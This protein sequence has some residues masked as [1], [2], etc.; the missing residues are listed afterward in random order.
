LTRKD[1]EK[2]HTIIPPAT[3]FSK[4]NQFLGDFAMTKCTAERKHSEEILCE[5]QNDLE[6]QVMDRTAELVRANA[7]LKREIEEHKNF[8]VALKK[9]EEQYRNLYESLPVAYLSINAA[10]GSILKCN[11][12]TL[13]MLGYSME[14]IQEME[15]IDLYADTPCGKAKAQEVFKRFQIGESI[16]DAVLEMKHKDGHPIWISLTVE[17]VKDDERNVIE[18]RSMAIDITQRYNVEEKLRLQNKILKNIVEGILL[19]RFSDGIIVYTSPALERIFGYESEELIGK[20]VSV[21]NAPT[22]KSPDETAQE[23]M[24]SLKKRK[25]WS[26]EIS[27]I[28][29]DGTPFWCHV[30]I[31]EFNDS[32]FDN[33]WVS[34]CEDI[35][36]RKQAESELLNRYYSLINNISEGLVEV[37][38]NWHMTFVNERFAEMTGFS[39]DELIGR[40]FS[41]L[42]S[43]QYHTK[44]EEELIRRRRGETGKYELELVKADGKKF[45][46]LCSPTPFYDSEGNYLGGAGVVADITERKLAEEQ[47]K[48]ALREKEVLL[49]EVH[50][51]VKNNLAVVASLLNLQINRINDVRI[52]EALR[53]N[54][55][56]IKTIAAIHECIYKSDNMAA[57]SFGIYSRHLSNNLLQD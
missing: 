50:H 25:Y 30:N 38:E 39:R 5:A 27:N 56:R 53:D 48:S 44:V 26:G 24:Q 2:I 35:T 47:I 55:D 10:D 9:K 13:K 21:L 28:K 12:M 11:K 14:S 16:R 43:K 18:S 7:Q 54:R 6:Q 32:R 36:E 34:V 1:G 15:I 23:I 49:R 57:I 33:V 40:R 42:A 29:K 17:V 46:A 37:D 20:H 4:D 51:R 8:E 41:E 45:Y 3:I 52:Q 22:T 19:V 31:S